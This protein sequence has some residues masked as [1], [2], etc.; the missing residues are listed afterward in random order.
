ML[1]LFLIACAPPETECREGTTLAEDGHCY[2]P[3]LDQA[4]RIED[5]IAGLPACEPATGPGAI[6]LV[7]GCAYGACARQLYVDMVDAIGTGS[8]ATT[9]F[10]ATQVYCTWS[11]WGVDALFADA[12][13]DDVPD[14]NARNE[15]IHLFR[16][17]SAATN[18]GV[19]VDANLACIF[20]SLGI[21]E[22]MYVIDSG[23]E[24]A[25]DSLVYEAYGLTVLDRTAAGGVARPDG[26][27]DDLYLYGQ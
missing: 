13:Q 2:P 21:P 24:L 12:D 27:V 19:G 18:E 16:P 25:I 23:G 5:V 15:R 10:S 3:L 11:D 4:P 22:D 17:S 8:C 14:A 26:F 6:D 1:H 9:N 20:D 7:G